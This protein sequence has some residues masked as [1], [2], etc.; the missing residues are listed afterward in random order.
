MEDKKVLAE[1]FLKN[2]V[3]SWKTRKADKKAVEEVIYPVIAMSHQPGSRGSLVAKEIAGRLKYDLFNREIITEIAKSVKMSDT[4]V[5]TLE[6]ERL[7]G[8]EDFISSLVKDQYLHPD[9]YLDHLLRVV[10]TIGN[11]GRSVIVGRGANFILPPEISFSVR[12][13]APLKL[14]IRN[15]AEGYQTDMEEAKRRVLKR[16]N[17][18][19]AFVRQSFHADINNPAHYDM[20]IN[21]KHLSVDTAAASVIAAVEKVSTKEFPA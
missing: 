9:L 2:Q 12:I 3:K 4:V 8:V 18:R 5:K 10:N 1:K 14:R 13:I 7:T 19:L 20:T 17:R 6:Q 11:H 21:M 15:V 16:E